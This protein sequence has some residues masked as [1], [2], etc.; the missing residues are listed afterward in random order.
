MSTAPRFILLTSIFA[1]ILAF[2]LTIV[3]KYWATSRDQ[4]Y[5][6]TSI[7]TLSEHHDR[8]NCF[9]VSK[10]G[11]FSS[12]FYT[13]EENW[14]PEFQK[15]NGHVIPGLWDGH[16]H[17][18]QYGGLLQSVDLFGS[19]SLSNAIERIV[20]YSKRHPGVGDE[21]EWITGIGYVDSYHF[22]S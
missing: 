8:A 16:G 12:V 20:E 15:L 18:Q 21:K 13:R 7:K 3:P 10:L 22:A 19:Q 5:C 4:T 6:Y 17:L 14:A 9:T 2:I 11:T 1:A